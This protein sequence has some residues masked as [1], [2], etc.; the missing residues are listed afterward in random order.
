M[1]KEQKE[2]WHTWT[3]LFMRQV[4]GKQEVLDPEVYCLIW[5]EVVS[6]RIHAS[7]DMRIWD[8]P[9]TICTC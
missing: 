9:K 4:N 5:E 1:K 2:R 6:G 7:D 8:L 3:K